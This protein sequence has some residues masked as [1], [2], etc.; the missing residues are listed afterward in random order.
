MLFRWGA[1]GGGIFQIWYRG[2]DIGRLISGF[3]IW[4]FPGVLESALP[5]RNPTSG[6]SWPEYT[7]TLLRHYPQQRGVLR[8]F[9]IRD[10]CINTMYPL[11]HHF[12]TSRTFSA[13]AASE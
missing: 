6:A 11:H 1:W 13:N 8:H 7:T 12:S 9:T 2:F 5:M 3:D 10:I 4:A